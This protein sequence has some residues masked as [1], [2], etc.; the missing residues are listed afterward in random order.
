MRGRSFLCDLWFSQTLRQKNYIYVVENR[1]ATWKIRRIL[2]VDRQTGKNY[3]SALV[4][5]TIKNSKPIYKNI[6]SIFYIPN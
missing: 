4:L 2:L 5:C 1:R 3:A 6:K